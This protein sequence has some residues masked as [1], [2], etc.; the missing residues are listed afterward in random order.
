[1]KVIIHK[2]KHCN[3]AF[4]ETDNGWLSL[5]SM[6]KDDDQ[7]YR[8]I[9]SGVDI[10]DAKEDLKKRKELKRDFKKCPDFLKEISKERISEIPRYGR[11]LAAA[12]RQKLLFDNACKGIALAAKNLAYARHDYEYE[13]F[14]ILEVQG[15]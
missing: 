7:Y 11:E 13:D 4:A 5:F 8:G 6:L 2:G 3:V 9:S 14:E 15:L 1:M 10:A 12:E